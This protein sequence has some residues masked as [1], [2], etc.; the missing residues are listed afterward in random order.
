[1]SFERIIY[2]GHAVLRMGQRG[3]NTVEIETILNSGLIIENYPSETP[4]PSYLLLCWSGN[5]PIH[6]VAA[7]SNITQETIIISVYEPTIQRW[8][9]DFFKRK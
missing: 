4:Y 1:M 6:I 5:R 8:E 3:I 2:S 9:S 7:D